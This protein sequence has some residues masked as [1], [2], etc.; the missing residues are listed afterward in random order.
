MDASLLPWLLWA[1]AILLIGVG[2][3]G[4]I[5]PV[6]PGIPLAFAGFWLGAHIDGYER[7]SV[8]TVVVLAI[9]TVIAMAL[10]F[11]AS[12][13]GAQRVGASRQAITGALLGSIVGIFFGLPGLILGPFVGA[14]I[15]E[16]SARRDVGQAATVGVAT[17]VG[18]L[19]G[20]VAKLAISLAMLG[21]F[22]F[23]Y[24]I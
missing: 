11:I 12:A 8:M 3:A 17:W 14:V 7:V 24:F 18:L 23:A 2:L 19:L 13:M 4:I 16:L 5:V 10:D 1:L 15:G 20:T 6:L 22:V 21:I 9:L